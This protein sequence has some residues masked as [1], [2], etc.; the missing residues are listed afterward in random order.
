MGGEENELCAADELLLRGPHNVTNALAAAAAAFEMGADPAMI[1]VGLRSFAPVEHRLEPVGVLG[2]VEY[3]N[4]SKATNP[5]STVVALEAYGD[6][7][8]VLMLGG[9]RSGASFTDLASLMPDRV[10][11]V[12]AFGEAAADIE[13]DVT[14]AVPVV[15][16]GRLAE[17]VARAREQALP[18]DAVI[19]SP[20]CKSFDEF[21]DYEERGRVF[22]SLVGEMG[23]GESD[24]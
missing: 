21:E 2:D 20:A 12:I 18:G 3:V 7:S 13:A 10:R 4:D 17:A 11:S 15:R 6:R 19:L 1:G 22:T 5:E 14:G 16:A 9:Y 8:V 24:G 23:S